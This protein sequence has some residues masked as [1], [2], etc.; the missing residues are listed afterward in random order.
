VHGRIASPIAV[1][2][3]LTA[4]AT[5]AQATLRSIDLGDG[6]QVTLV[7]RPAGTCGHG[8]P[9]A[10]WTAI[11]L[12]IA[13]MDALLV[14]R[15]YARVPGSLRVLAAVPPMPSWALTT[16]RRWPAASVLY[17]DD[18][19]AS[20][21]AARWP[22]ANTAE[23]IAFSEDGTLGIA[24]G[25]SQ[26]IWSSEDRGLSWVE[27]SSSAGLRYVDV[28]VLGRAVVIV[29][30]GRAAWVSR[31][32]GFSLGSAADEVS[33]PL[34]VEGEAIVI[35]TEHGEVRIDREGRRAP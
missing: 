4:G 14:A 1:V 9:C 16:W 3:L 18:R 26:G 32:R 15:T 23:A 17:T 29:D 6:M 34:R 8:A 19:G 24:V 20:W 25:A 10:L 12:D 27:R 7:A 28:A 21:A 35:P 13:R 33:G 5:V 31:D 22:A 2:V 11:G 30:E